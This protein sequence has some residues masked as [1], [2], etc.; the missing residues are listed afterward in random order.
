MWR[1]R[2]VLAVVSRANLALL[3]A[4]VVASTHSECS[5]DPANAPD[6]LALWLKN[7]NS[8]DAQAR[9]EAITKMG[10][11]L[12]PGV[13]GELFSDDDATRARAL[14]RLDHAKHKAIA[15]A[16]IERLKRNI[17]ANDGYKDGTRHVQRGDLTL[18]VRIES[19]NEALAKALADRGVAEA[20]PLLKQAHAF[21][22]QRPPEERNSSFTHT[23]AH[24]IYR[25]SAECVQLWEA[26]QA[27]LYQPSPIQEEATRRFLRPDLT[28]TN[29]LT[30][31]LQV[32]SQSRYPRFLIG[33]NP[34]TITLRLSNHTDATIPVDL[35]PESFTFSC[36]T[37][38]R[39][40]VPAKLL[41]RATADPAL[42]SILP[43]GS[44]TLT[45]KLERLKETAL[46]KPLR[47]GGIS[48]KA[49]YIPADE[50]IKK[51]WGDIALVS[52]SLDRPYF[53]RSDADAAPPAAGEAGK[54]DPKGLTYEQ[55]C[56]ML[57]TDRDAPLRANM[58]S[59]QIPETLPWLEKLVRDPQQG[60]FA[61]RNAIAVLG[62]IGSRAARDFLVQVL[63]AT[64][65]PTYD[66]GG[67]LWSRLVDSVARCIER[68]TEKELLEDL[69]H[70]NPH[71]RWLAAMQLG[72]RKAAAAAP[73][74][75][76]LLDDKHPDPRLGATWALGEI[77]DPKGIEE[78]I[79]IVEKR[80]PG[81]N[82]ISAIEALGKVATPRCVEAIESV[83]KG[84]PEYWIAAKTIE[85]LLKRSEKPVLRAPATPGPP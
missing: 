19:E 29:G 49:I 6:E 13:S 57:A 36:V 38:V 10:Q 14:L 70:G 3:A 12:D 1:R 80:R 73:E 17:K 76:R 25:L 63:E 50:A 68:E 66:N 7:I 59:L 65:Q 72:K 22:M 30:A 28:P 78:L 62:R 9:R 37:D 69:R 24:C 18:W 81:G 74:L 51:Q 67:S 82:R 46:G 39:T 34:L 83:K 43:K 15:D 42:K 58:V 45:W 27:K 40:N 11:W 21:M 85:E 84:D 26:G 48:L 32:S 79:A 60:D 64:E 52:N 20:V 75:I 41:V 8:E 2:P 44:V 33:A 55:V 77:R 71:V 47:V 23:L 5:G 31:S 53:D 54:L 61:R 4:L 16:L 35:S 56:A